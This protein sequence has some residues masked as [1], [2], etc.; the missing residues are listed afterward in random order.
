M[1]AL[2]RVAAIAMA[3]ATLYYAG[4]LNS[5]VQ[6]RPDRPGAL[7]VVLAIAAAL[8]VIALALRGT[9]RDDARSEPR[10]PRA[11]RVA[12]LFI[13]VMATVSLAWLFTVPRRHADDWTPYHNDAIALNECAARLV[14]E[15]KDP[16]AALDIFDCYGRLGLGADRTT[17]LR[18]GLFADVT[19]YPTDD[20]LDAAW[21]LRSRDGGNVEFVSRPSY[22]SLS[23][24]LLVPFV[25]MG[26]DTNYLYAACLIA[27]MGLLCW[28]APAG[29]RPFVLTGLL[30]ASCLAA[31]T[32]GGSADLLYALPLVIAWIWRERLG[33]ALA[34][35]VAAAI[36]QIAWFVTPFWLIAIGARDGWRAAL[37]Q[38]AASAA[39]F[40]VV[41]LPFALW[42][43]ADWLAG[44]LTPVTA[45][46]FPRGAGLVFAATN[47]DL[48]LW[49][50]STYLALEGLAML[51]CLLI[52]WRTRRTSPEIGIALALIPLF[53]A[54]RSLFSYFFLIP[55][56]AFAGLVRMPLG[57]LTAAGARDAGA[58]TL[59]ALPAKLRTVARHERAA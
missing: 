21:A 33:G 3:G 34:F 1:R 50:A 27:A 49:G 7:A 6:Q 35:G 13:C 58:L 15:G 51:A 5:I 53:F 42:H 55:L 22:P 26:V 20:Q 29:L 47:G 14:L 57:D 37:R 17:P 36:K 39:V 40:V 48:P 45:P 18:D 52:A 23:F 16:Y 32:V 31:F 28:R 44:V 12:W 59:F 30:G 24:V 9:G 56:F 4:L 46:M 25:A 19:V 41:N 11:N 38:G 8:L 54:W 43:P 10:Y 2:L